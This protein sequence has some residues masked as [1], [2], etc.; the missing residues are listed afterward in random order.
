MHNS[1]IFDIKRYAINDGPGIRVVIF[2]KGCNLHCAW[3]HNPE[4]ISSK[5]EKMY[6][7]SK[8]IKCGTCIAACPEKAI[9]MGSDGVVTNPDLCKVCGKCADVCPTKAI[10]MSGKV[11]TIPEI[12]D[13]IEKERIFFDQSG[14]G[15]TFSGG[16]PLI[17]SKML[18]ELLDECKR[19]KIHT[20]VDTAGNVS[21]E[22]IL[23][24][25]K[26]TDLFL[27]DLKM[28]DSD[29]H[30]KWVNTSNEKILQ[31]LKAISE[32]GTQI[33]IRIPLIGGINDSIKNIEQ[34]AKF[35]SEL[36]GEKKEVNLLPYHNIAQNKYMKLGKSEDFSNLREPDKSI[37]PILILKFNEYGI[38]A[39]V[40]G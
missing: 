22:T 14:G 36:A 21:T 30:K 20:A 13:I 33:I 38:K 34:T 10:E 40:G 1:L 11:M 18:I 39:T 6:A 17:H 35:I 29:L 15:V 16:E 2:F 37:L 28:I 3:C 12:M 8:C 5:V 19:R 32:I 9:T 4:S 23:E 26:R 25:A 27:Y 24:V 7:P 31:N